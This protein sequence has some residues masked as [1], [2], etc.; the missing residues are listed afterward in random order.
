M[1]KELPLQVA[2]ISWR[3]LNKG[4]SI[5]LSKVDEMWDILFGAT[6][7]KDERYV[8]ISVKEWLD[9][10]LRSIGREVVLREQNGELVVLTDEQAVGYLDAQANSGLRKHKNS[11][12]RMFTAIDVSNLTQH[13]TDQLQ[14]KQAKH[15]LISAAAE[16]ARK[17]AITLQRRGA[18]L[19]QL[20]P[21]SED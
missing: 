9:K 20:K 2:G 6:R 14:S 18:K 15:A 3:N 13:Q 12:R 17:Q 16:G 8:S 21:P 4:D 1:S 10:A 7:K 19:P 11:T 5:P